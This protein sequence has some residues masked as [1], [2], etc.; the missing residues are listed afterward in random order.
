MYWDR[1][2]HQDINSWILE[3][4]IKTGGADFVFYRQGNLKQAIVID[5]GYNKTS[6]KPVYQ[7]LKSYGLYGLVITTNSNLRL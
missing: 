1:I 5:V 3:R 6:T 7:T 4:D 2:N